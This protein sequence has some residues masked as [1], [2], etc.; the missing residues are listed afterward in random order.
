M[1]MRTRF[2]GWAAHAGL[3][4]AVGL[5]ASC[6]SGELGGELAARPK[7]HALR[8]P[9]GVTIRLPQ[10]EPFAI[11][12][13]RSSRQVGLGGEAAADA[14]A[15]PTGEAEARASVTTS[16]TAE[17]VFQLGHALLNETDRQ[18]DLDLTVRFRYSFEV[19]QA[20]ESR[21][22]DAV[23]GLRLFARDDRGRL[24]RELPLVQHSTENG[25]AQRSA[26]ECVQFTLTLAPGGAVNVFLAG[27]T[28]VDIPAERSAAALLKLEGLQFE[29][30]TRPAPA[31][32][33]DGK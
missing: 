16:G 31:V 3:T 26:D 10:D 25:A 7:P 15:K 24:L 14:T 23:L 8:Q 17:G 11:A 27:Q 5:F 22:A 13:P 33:A 9:E 18:T 12:L 29:V 19:T 2:A 20:T 4:L 1:M 32:R 28:K 30:V 6:T 21:L